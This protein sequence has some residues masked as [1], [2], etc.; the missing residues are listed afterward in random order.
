[1]AGAGQQYYD[2][3]EA[4]EILRRAVASSPSVGGMSREGLLKAAEELGL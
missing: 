1:M 2:D 4:E 3:S